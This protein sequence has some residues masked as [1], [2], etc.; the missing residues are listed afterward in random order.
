MV[1]HLTD[2]HNFY[3]MKTFN[4]VKSMDIFLHYISFSLNF[5]ILFFFLLFA[6]ALYFKFILVYSLE[7]MMI[8][9]KNLEMYCRPC[10]TIWD[11]KPG[12]GCILKTVSSSEFVFI[13]PAPEKIAQDDE[14][15]NHRC[16]SR[17]YHFHIW[18]LFP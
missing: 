13:L 17:L 1:Y 4:I 7:G 5:E 14:M 16:L 6:L 2:S 18:L 8:M 9:Y 15:S 10:F 12:I 11:K 3:C